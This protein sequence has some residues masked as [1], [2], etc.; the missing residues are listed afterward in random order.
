MRAAYLIVTI[1]LLAGLAGCG[2]RHLG[3]A[4]RRDGRPAPNCVIGQPRQRL[5]TDVGLPHMLTARGH[6][7][8]H[9]EQ[10][11]HIG[12]P[13]RDRF[14]LDPITGMQP[15][16]RRHIYAPDP[17]GIRGRH[18]ES[19]QLGV[20]REGFVV[21]A[22]HRRSDNKTVARRH[23]CKGLANSVGEQWVRA[24]FD[25]GDVVFGGFRDG[26]AEPHRVTQ[27]HHPVVGVKLR[28]PTLALWGSEFEAA[29]MVD[30][31][32]I[33]RDFAEDLTTAPIA[34][35]GHLPQEEQ[36]SA[37]SAALTK[38]LAPWQG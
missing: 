2:Q 22:L 24:D 19:G 4:G 20:E 32:E 13:R 18:T 23:R 3:E 37:V 33:W 35:A 10:R 26:L 21:A 6:F 28:C 15:R 25:E 34:L 5:D 38:F 30:M 36:P 31:A 14:L 7:N 9:P 16:R 11:V 27:V 17:S 12:Q 8:V 1:A 29:K